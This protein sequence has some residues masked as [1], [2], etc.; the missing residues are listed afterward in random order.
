MGIGRHGSNFD[1]RTRGLGYIVE[2]SRKLESKFLKTKALEGINHFADSEMKSRD[3]AVERRIEEVIKILDPWFY[4]LEPPSKANLISRSPTAEIILFPL[5]PFLGF[6]TGVLLMVFTSA[7]KLRAFERVFVCGFLGCFVT[8]G[9]AFLVRQPGGIVPG[10]V[11]YSAS[12]G[13]AVSALVAGLKP[14][15]FTETV[16]GTKPGEKFHPPFF[17]RG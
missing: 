9:S 6:M 13:F 11:Y 7:G 8:L 10:M 16:R 1:H 14:Y 12:L 17:G 5:A 15:W 2:P 3:H 4:V